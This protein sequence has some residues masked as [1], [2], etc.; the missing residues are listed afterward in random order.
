[1]GA[2]GLEIRRDGFKAETRLR[3]APH[4]RAPSYG[5]A[6]PELARETR[7]RRRVAESAGFP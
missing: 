2:H 4:G 7:E 6:T 1:M 3:L 5:V